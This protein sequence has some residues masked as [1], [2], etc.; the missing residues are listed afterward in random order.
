ML[1]N[2]NV[3][4]YCAVSANLNLNFVSMIRCC[5]KTFRSY[6]IIVFVWIYISSLPKCTIKHKQPLYI[7]CMFPYTKSYYSLFATN[8]KRYVSKATCDKI[9]SRKLYTLYIRIF[10]WQCISYFFIITTVLTTLGYTHIYKL[11][12]NEQ[13][14]SVHGRGLGLGLTVI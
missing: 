8:Y 3:G 6:I 1:V 7:D 10:F 2:A 9:S 4:F 5:K 14:S 12:F 11:F 13:V